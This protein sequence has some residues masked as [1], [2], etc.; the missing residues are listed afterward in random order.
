MMIGLYNL[1]NSFTLPSNRL[2]VGFGDRSDVAV[3][4]KTT[5]ETYLTSI[6]DSQLLQLSVISP[7]SVKENIVLSPSHKLDTAAVLHAL[8]LCDS[9][10][11]L[12]YEREALQFQLEPSTGR[13]RSLSGDGDKLTLNT[14]SSQL[15]PTATDV[16]TGSVA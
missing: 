10:G 16:H 5:R 11:V 6:T 7:C 9:F 14:F 13:Q 3:T 8:N 12:R 1:F 4:G 2:F 15:I